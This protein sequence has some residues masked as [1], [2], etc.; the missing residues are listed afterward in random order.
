MKPGDLVSLLVGEWASA[1]R[2]WG[3]VIMINAAAPKAFVYFPHYKEHELGWHT[4]D[5]WHVQH[6][7][8]VIP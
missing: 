5:D 3:T 6:F 7:W 4:V 8:K 1:R 2:Y